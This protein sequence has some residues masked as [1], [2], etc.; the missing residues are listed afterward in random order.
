MINILRKF[1]RNEDGNI[2]M[3]AGLTFPILV[4][5]SMGALDY[6]TVLN[7]KQALDNAANTAAL[8]AVNEA[9]IAYK[10]L[11][12]VDLEE[13]I[14]EV[15]EQSFAATAS[16]IKNISASD[17]KANA[18]VEKNT[19]SVEVNYSATYD[20]VFGKFAGKDTL[21][22]TGEASASASAE[23]YMNFTF[24]FDVSASM[25]IGASIDDQ[26]KVA[27]VAGG[28]AFSCHINATDAAPSTY[29]KA[30]ANDAVMR[31]DVAREA[32]LNTLDIIT[33]N[34][35]KNN[36]FTA[37]AYIFD[38]E[39][40]E[41]ANA[42]DSRASDMRH[43][44]NT[45]RDNVFMRTSHGG[46]DLDEAMERMAALLPEGGAGRSPDDRRQILVVLTDGVQDSALFYGGGRGGHT[47]DRSTRANWPYFRQSWAQYLY[48][49]DPKKC[50]ALKE[51]NIEIFFVH[52]NYLIPIVPEWRNHVK[53]MYGFIDTKLEPIMPRRFEDCT[54]NPRSVFQASTPAE[55]ES[56]FNELLSQT[57]APL[58]LN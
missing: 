45:I 36:Q 53:R 2:A 27:D 3:T 10:N 21:S 33:K 15:A 56:A 51:K 50:E 43:V 18:K 5:M 57:T 47:L 41:I 52:T 6:G 9:V 17:I 54:E 40:V 7:R 11:E 38:N 25:G 26:Q 29:D 23:A 14:K 28:C 24:L 46:T 48:A 31:I 55:I 44:G 22:V 42:L 49:L 19:L 30:R 35:T 58:H 37:G 34:T 13:M 39:V 4:A 1:F 12:E 8:S 16:N 32:A 20:T